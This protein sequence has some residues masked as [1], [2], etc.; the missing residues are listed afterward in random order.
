MDTLVPPVKVGS[1]NAIL[2][3]LPL[4]DV[5]GALGAAGT[6]AATIVRG[7]ENGPHPYKFFA[8]TFKL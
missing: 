7:D 1:V 3:L 6:V 2:T 4:Y 5:V 8:L